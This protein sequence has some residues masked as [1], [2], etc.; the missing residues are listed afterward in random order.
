MYF[1]SISISFNTLYKLTLRYINILYNSII[2]RRV[3]NMNAREELKPYE[4]EIKRY[5]T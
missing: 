3:R 2:E 5:I 1:Y 4:N